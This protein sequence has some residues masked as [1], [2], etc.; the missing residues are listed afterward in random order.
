LPRNWIIHDVF[1][2]SLVEPYRTGNLRVPADPSK[3]LRGAD[4][5]E[6]SEEY[7]DDEAMGSTEKGRRVVYL[8]KWLDYLDR[9]NWT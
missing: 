2:T 7:D 4:D 1:H 8:V 3:A 5:I 6:Q 9:R